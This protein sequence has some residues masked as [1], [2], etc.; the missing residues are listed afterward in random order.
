[1]G[2]ALRYSEYPMVFLPKLICLCRVS[3]LL[4]SVSTALD[5]LVRGPGAHKQQM[6]TQGGFEATKR[7]LMHPVSAFVLSDAWNTVHRTR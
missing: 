2:T 7:L 6:A 3:S 1:M 4:G 5:G